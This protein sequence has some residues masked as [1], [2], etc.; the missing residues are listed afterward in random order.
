ML[1]LKFQLKMMRSSSAI[2]CGIAHLLGLTIENTVFCIGSNSHGQLGLPLKNTESNPYFLPGRDSHKIERVDSLQEIETT[3]NCLFKQISCGDYHSLLLTTEGTLYFSGKMGRMN[4]ETLKL[5]ESNNKFTKIMAFYETSLA[6]NENNEVEIWGKRLFKAE[7]HPF[8]KPIHTFQQAML[9]CTDYPFTLDPLI[10]VIEEDEKTGS[11]RNSKKFKS[12]E[13]VAKNFDI[14][15]NCP[16]EVSIFSQTENEKVIKEKTGDR[17]LKT[18][19]KAF[20]NPV[21][22]DFK[23]KNKKER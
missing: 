19:A 10:F 1:L 3:D 18:M 23:I 17:V 20:N 16:S 8:P 22:N 2:S 7:K 9:S 21:N 11:K 15:E 6:M 13:K 5:I 12:S 14:D 4:S